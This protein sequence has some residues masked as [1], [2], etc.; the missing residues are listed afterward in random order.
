MEWRLFHLLLLVSRLNVRPDLVEELTGLRQA[1]G[2][3]WCE[4]WFQIR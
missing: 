2:E 3:R 1:L 4:W